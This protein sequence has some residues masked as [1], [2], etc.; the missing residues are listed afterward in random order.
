MAHIEKRRS[1]RHDSNGRMK[2]I[3]RYRVRYRDTKGRHHSETTPRLADAERRKSEIEH[4][5]ATATWHDPRRGDVQLE[6]WVDGW[7]PTRHD[8]RATTRVRLEVTMNRQ[9]LPRFGTTCLRDITN[10]DVRR[11]VVE[12][13][14]SGLSAATT[15]KAVFAL[16]QALEAA[17]AD[18]RLVHNPAAAVPLPT[19]RAK[20]PRYLSRPRLSVWW[21]RCRHGTAPSFLWVPTPG[22]A[23]ARPQGCAAE[24][25]IPCAPAS[26]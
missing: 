6:G 2:E 17:I 20:P 19:E 4:E 21:P 22:C 11:W 16:R 24:T 3:V 10:S 12:M 26:G 18:Q 5:M 1:Q 14:E 13:I 25:S 8:L 7:L 23:G 9:V 15:R